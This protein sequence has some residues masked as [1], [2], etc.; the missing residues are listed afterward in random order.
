LKWSPGEIP[1]GVKLC[2]LKKM[3][4][5]GEIPAGLGDSVEIPAE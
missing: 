2:R 5:T 4:E 3:N 1:A